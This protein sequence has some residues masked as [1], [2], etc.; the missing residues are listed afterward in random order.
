MIHAQPI[1]FIVDDDNS[2]QHALAMLVSSAGWRAQTF[3]CAEAFLALGDTVQNAI[4]LAYQGVA[5][6]TWPGVQFRRD[7]GGKALN[8]IY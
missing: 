4:D 6:I 5:K 8:Q 7:I 3:C 1:V 2:V